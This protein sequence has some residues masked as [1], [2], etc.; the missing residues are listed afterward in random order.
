MSD[1]PVYAII[2]A[3]GQQGSATA[4]AL[5]ADGAEVRAL[6][7]NTTSAPALAL[8]A[9]GV[10]VVTADIDDHA[11]LVSGLTGVDAAF[12]MT[13]YSGDGGTTGEVRH[14]KAIGDAAAAAGLPRIVY[15]SVGGA[16]RG[17]GIPH[18]ESK[19]Q[20]EQYLADRVPVEIVR[21][22]F[23]MDNLKRLLTPTDDAEI[24][25]AFPLPG[26]VPLQMVSVTDIGVIAA[27]ALQNPGTLTSD[28]LEI[29]GDELTGE[30]I[31]T[32]VG[33]HLGKP[34]VYVQL[35]LEALGADD[36]R[37]AMFR[38]FAQLPAYQA[39]FSTTQSLHPTVATFE[40]WITSLA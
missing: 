33:R 10:E 23:F 26:D 17:T 3:T 31:A 36:D 6:V 8:A 24:T 19:R 20:I 37:K 2:G 7:R 28:G 38:W 29:S 27:T 25:V 13:T 34:V 11:S 15:S 30:Q 5:R 16:E 35:P 21:P 9:L 22:T 40:Q 4:R 12:A 14:G 39:D 1:S 18:F 32:I